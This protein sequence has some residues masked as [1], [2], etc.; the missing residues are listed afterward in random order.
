MLTQQSIAAI[1]VLKDSHGKTVND[2]SCKAFNEMPKS[3]RTPTSA[4]TDTIVNSEKHTRVCLPLHKHKGLH[5]VKDE[6]GLTSAYTNVSKC[7]SELVFMAI[8]EYLR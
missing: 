5:A 1:E 3:F 7:E 4:F 6:I 8:W 2:C